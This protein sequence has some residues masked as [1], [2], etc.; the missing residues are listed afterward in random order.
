MIVVNVNER[1]KITNRVV[2]RFFFVIFFDLERDAYV[3]INEN[4]LVVFNKKL[5]VIILQI[6]RFVFVRFKK[7]NVARSS[8]QTRDENYRQIFCDCDISINRIVFDFTCKIY[9]Y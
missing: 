6:I 5:N 8:V 2:T 7:C 9:S 1:L 3:E 4:R